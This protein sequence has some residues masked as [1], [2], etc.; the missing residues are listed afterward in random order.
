MLILKDKVKETIKRYKLLEPG[1]RILAGVS[2]GPDSLCLFHLLLSLRR[3]LQIEVFAGHLNH[4]FRPEA[5][6]ELDY[7][8]ALARQWEV[9]FFGSRIDTPAYRQQTGLS[10]QEAARY[11]RYRFLMK[12]AE[13]FGANKIATGHHCDDQV[14]TVLLN[15]IHGAGLDGLAGIKPCRL[16][17]GV[18]I[19]RPLLESSKDDI[20]NYCRE[21]AIEPVCDESNLKTIY[22]RNKVRLELIPY[23]EKELNPRIGNAVLR[24]S[25][26]AAEDNEYMEKTARHYL[27]LN[28]CKQGKE[29]ILLKTGALSGL[30]LSIQRRV[31]RAAWQKI[32][33]GLPAALNAGHIDAII[34]LYQKG[35]TGKEVT[36]PGEKKAYMV[37]NGL[38]ISAQKCYPATNTYS[39][40]VMLKVPGIT[41]LPGTEMVFEADLQDPG[42]LKWP[43]DKKKEAYLD[44]EKLN[45]PLSVRY[46]RKG[47]KFKPLGMG[48]RKRKLKDIF[49]DEKVPRQERDTYPLVAAGDKIVWVTGLAVSHVCRVTDNT[50]QVLVLRVKTNRK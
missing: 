41:S 11:C 48:G 29:K 1:D 8:R 36:L 6:H 22:R 17:K 25:S 46:R 15:I 19:I 13:H 26:L 24:L 20:N 10:A 42:D 28:S 40:S 3:E 16:W 39:E 23:L 32:N 4:G 18:A 34:Q 49:I 35:H 9:P 27:N 33:R 38:I 31:L 21:H 50:G 43:P 7:V 14:E 12:G 2:G 45:L 5:E 44:Y 37:H 30:A 47:D